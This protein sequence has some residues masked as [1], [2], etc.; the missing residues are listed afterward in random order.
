MPNS[1]DSI[2][3][4]LHSVEAPS[5]LLSKLYG[6]QGPSSSASAGWQAPAATPS[7]TEMLAS[8][9]A[10]SAPYLQSPS[11]DSLQDPSLDLDVSDFN[12]ISG[13]LDTESCQAAELEHQNASVIDPPIISAEERRSIPDQLLKCPYCSK[14]FR[15]N[16]DLKYVASS[17]A[18]HP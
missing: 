5:T 14:S 2:L 15:R 1:N 6:E 13:T 16:C 8:P 9:F 18:L 11:F 3:P 12:R 4:S 7:Q 10:F 17:S